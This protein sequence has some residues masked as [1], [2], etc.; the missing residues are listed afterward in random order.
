MKLQEIMDIIENS[1]LNYERTIFCD[2]HHKR[3]EVL[4]LRIYYDFSMKP[5]NIIKINDVWLEVHNNTNIRIVLHPYSG[6]EKGVG[7]MTHSMWILMDLE[8]KDVNGNFTLH[9]KPCK[10]HTHIGFEKLNTL[11]IV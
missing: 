8:F 11:D 3:K 10:N 7:R 4:D 6:R 2:Q 1:D 5:S 9:N